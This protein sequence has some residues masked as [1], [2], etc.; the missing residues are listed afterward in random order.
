MN[1]YLNAEND[2]YAKYVVGYKAR[3]LK[4]EEELALLAKAETVLSQNGITRG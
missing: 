1:G 4:I 3:L 2:A